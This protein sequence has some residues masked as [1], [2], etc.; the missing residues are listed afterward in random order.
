MS[1]TSIEFQEPAAAH[2]GDRIERGDG[3]VTSA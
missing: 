3:L 1:S 2:R